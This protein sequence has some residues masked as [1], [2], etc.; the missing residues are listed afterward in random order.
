[1]IRQY[2]PLQ[3]VFCYPDDLNQVW[4]NLIHNALQAMDYKGKLTI[5][6]RKQDSHALVAISDTGKGIPDA[7]KRKIFEPFFT[8]KPAGE[9][10]GLGLNIVKKIIEKHRGTITFESQPGKTTFYVSLPIR[11]TVSQNGSIFQK[12]K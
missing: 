1:V 3:P 10:S 4:E 12:T 5:A 6:V 8:T 11:S 7:M 9:G 2:E